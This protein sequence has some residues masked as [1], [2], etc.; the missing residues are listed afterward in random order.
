M[1]IDIILFIIGFVFLIK[2]ADIMVDGSS[3]IA[4]RFGVS[5]FFIGLTVVAFGTSAPE[6]V[7]SA[8]ASIKGSTGIAM[9]NIIGSN[10]SNSL[11]ILGIAAIIAPLVVKRATIRKEIP[12]SLL[13][14]LAVGFLVNDVMIDNNG[15]NLLSRIDGLVLILFFT[16]FIVYTFGISREKP[17]IMDRVKGEIEEGPKEYSMINSVMMIVVGLMGLALGGRW[18]VN[19]AISFAEAFGISEA[20]IGLTIVAIGT[21]LPELAASAVAAYKGKTDIAVGNVVGSNIFNLLWVLGIAAIIRPIAY[22]SVLNIDFT[23]LFTLTVLL[24]FL[25]YFGKKN[26]LA[27]W[28]GIV[29]LVSYVVYIIYLIVRG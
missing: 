7:V 21:S 22:D 14:V 19:G 17:G 10:I 24:L 15:P 4:K 18:I 11:L 28:E 6:L 9:G 20:L 2:G 25:I 8:L 1:F 13:G 23:V 5:A 26:V 12:Y 16:I 27:R 3:S 29:L